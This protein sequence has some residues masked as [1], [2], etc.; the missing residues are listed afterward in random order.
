[1]E[2]RLGGALH[3]ATQTGDEAGDLTRRCAAHRVADADAVH[4]ESVDR[5]V[6]IEELALV[7]PEGSSAE[8]RTS[9]PEESR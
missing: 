6:E 5:C 4:A 1:M 2:V 7:A 8:K 3:S 9:S